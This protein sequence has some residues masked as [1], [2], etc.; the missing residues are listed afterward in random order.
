[1]RKETASYY[2]KTFAVDH[3][4]NSSLE[5]A[6]KD[7]LKRLDAMDDKDAAEYFFDMH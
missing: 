7:H 3:L 4:L 6:L 2:T 5:T 1:M